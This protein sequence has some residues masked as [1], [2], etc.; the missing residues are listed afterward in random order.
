MSS[1]EEFAASASKTTVF[2][3]NLL[4]GLLV[5]CVVLWVMDVPRQAFNVSFYTE[6]LLTVCLG[7]T[8]ALAF[9]VETRREYRRIRSRRRDRR[10]HHPGLYRLPVPQSARHSAAALDRSWR[11]AC[12]YVSREPA[13]LRALVRLSLRGSFAHSLRLHLRPLRAADLRA[14]HAADR[15]HRRQRDPV[16]PGAGGQPPHLGHGLRLDHPGDGGLRL[17][18]PEPAGRLP[19]PLGVAGA[20]GRLSRARR[21]QHDRRDPRPSRC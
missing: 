11:R 21:E 10:R 7:L 13:R 1:A 18:Q 4:Q 9:L 17:H 12:L 20:D 14:R 2:L 5:A 16:V 15:R 8:L 19:D 3:T 6:Q